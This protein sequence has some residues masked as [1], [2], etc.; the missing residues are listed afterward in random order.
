MAGAA[1]ISP[2]IFI[3][4]IY[5]IGPPGSTAGLIAEIGFSDMGS[6]GFAGGAST[7]AGCLDG[8]T[9]G[10]SGVFPCSSCH[11]LLSPSCSPDIYPSKNT[12]GNSLSHLCLIV[13]GIAPVGF[14]SL[15]L[16][17]LI[18]IYFSFSF[19]KSFRCEAMIVSLFSLALVSASITIILAS[20]A[21]FSSLTASFR[22]FLPSR[23]FSAKNA[24]F[25][26]I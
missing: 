22:S 12:S 4:S 17:S 13:S 23:Y 19:S 18:L 25:P 2:I 24:I 26:H 8:L 5:A 3:A 7:G 16:S 10:C 21:A 11:S 15:Y 1:G 14:I 9:D 6:A 20:N